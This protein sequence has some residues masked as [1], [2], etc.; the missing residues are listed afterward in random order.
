MVDVVGKVIRQGVV[1]LPPGARIKD[2][3]D[4]AG[5][6]LPGTDLTSLDLARRLIDGDQVFVGIPPPSGAASAAGGGVVAGDPQGTPTLGGPAGSAGQA[7]QAAAAVDLNAATAADL[8]TLPGVGVVTAQRILAF[9]AA[10]G[11]TTERIR[12]EIHR[13]E[14]RL[15]RP[16]GILIHSDGRPGSRGHEHTG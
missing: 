10:H 12:R 14:R 7:G 8:E 16:G 5:G 4:A 9:R 3:I 13:Q 2:A 11:R 1:T 15:L 6:V